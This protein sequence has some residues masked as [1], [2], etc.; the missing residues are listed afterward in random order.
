MS[1]LRATTPCPSGIGGLRGPPASI[2]KRRLQRMRA[3][4]KL[5]PPRRPSSQISSI[6]LRPESSFAL[7]HKNDSLDRAL[8]SA[9]AQTLN[10]VKFVD[11]GPAVL[12]ARFHSAYAFEVVFAYWSVRWP[13]YLPLGA[14]QVAACASPFVVG[15]APPPPRG[16]T[17]LL[18]RRNRAP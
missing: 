10:M 4:V 17:V 11:P 8:S 12:L 2:I 15:A 5:A 1:E 3:C 6:A 14:N 13:V 16:G 7:E 9:H 18:P